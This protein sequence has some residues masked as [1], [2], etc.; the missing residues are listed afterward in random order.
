MFSP[1]LASSGTQAG[2]GVCP[3]KGGGKGF[4]PGCPGGGG[5][6]EGGWCFPE[7]LSP[8]LGKVG[9]KNVNSLTVTINS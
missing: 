2:G 1:R 6:G 4:C 5:E 8:A 3:L 9:H 7:S